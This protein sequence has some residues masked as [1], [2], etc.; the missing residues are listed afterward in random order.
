MEEEYVKLNTAILLKEKGFNVACNNILKEDGS[1]MNTLFR[2]NKD[3]P[4]GCYSQ[5]SQ[6]IASKWLRE[7]KN[8]YIN[9]YNNA[10]GYGYIICKSSNGTFISDD[11]MSGPNEGGVWDT[12]EEALEAGLSSCLDLLK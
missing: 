6:S 7:T 2:A 5:P 9:I 11:C 12:Y 1:R 4:R 10:C 3:L 8:L